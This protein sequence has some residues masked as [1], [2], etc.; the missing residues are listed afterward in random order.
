MCLAK[1]LCIFEQAWIHDL[2]GGGALL[3]LM[4]V[5]PVLELF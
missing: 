5:C 2:L 1:E 3:A 4:I